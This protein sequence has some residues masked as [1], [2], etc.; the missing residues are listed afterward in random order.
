ML[1]IICNSEAIK[2]SKHSTKK[3]CS[4]ECSDIYRKKLGQQNAFNKH[5][6][7]KEQKQERIDS[8]DWN[9][10]FKSE[11]K[12]VVLAEQDYKCA[13]CKNSMMWE[14]KPL[15]FDLDH[16]DGDRNNNRRSNLRCL[17]PN[18]HSQTPTYKSKNTTNKKYTDDQI[19][20]VIKQ[21]ISI[22]DVCKRLNLN[23][24]GRN[25]ARITNIAKKYDLKVNYIL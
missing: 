20:E 16:I 17:C 10:L 11:H 18:C 22:Y 13:I 2:Y 21:S 6:K 24:H 25:Y 5:I 19:I 12:D 4:K 15:G 14:G 23:P 8:G 3:F 7:Y 1:C 9:L